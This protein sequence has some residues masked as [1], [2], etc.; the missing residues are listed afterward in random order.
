MNQLSHCRADDLHRALATPF[1]SLARRPDERDIFQYAEVGKPARVTY[2]PEPG[3][4]DDARQAK[5]SGR[6][7]RRVVLAADGS[8]K[9]IVPEESLGHGLTEETIKAVRGVRFEP[10]LRSGR[11]VS[12]IALIE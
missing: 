7:R 5:V 12:Q 6:V 11:A 9:H 4:T 2:K 10:A 3:F 1:E 8:V